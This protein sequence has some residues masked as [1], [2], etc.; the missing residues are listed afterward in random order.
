MWLS[1][2]DPGSADGDVTIHFW[3]MAGR[4][5]VA[6]SYIPAEW[7]DRIEPEIDERG[8]VHLLWR[9]WHNGQGHG[10]VRVDG[11]ARYTHREVVERVEKRKLS[12]FDYVDH[13]CTRKP[14]L[15]YECLEV[16]P[17][18]ENTRR[19]PGRRTQFKTVGAYP[20][21]SAAPVIGGVVDEYA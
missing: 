18:G 5:I 1:A 7:L 6:P 21:L 14:C 17:P 13:R 2:M 12:R 9:G 16:V 10:K 19:G 8:V 4:I 20:D 3:F 15:T 11:K